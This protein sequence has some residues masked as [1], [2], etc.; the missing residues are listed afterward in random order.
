MTLQQVIIFSQ[1]QQKRNAF[2]LKALV[3]LVFITVWID[4]FFSEVQSTS[5]YLSESLLFSS[6]WLLFLPL[7]N[8]QWKMA[9]RRPLKGFLYAALA[10]AIHL[11]SYPALVW[12]ISGCF[13]GHTF[14][15]RQTFEYGLTTYFI[16]TF[17][18]YGLSVPVIAL[19]RASSLALKSDDL[20]AGTS[21]HKTLPVPREE[22]A[23]RT[24]FPRSLLVPDTNN[25]KTLIQTT[26]ILYFTA[27]SPYINV[28]HPVKKYLLTETLR[29]L[30]TRLS[31]NQFVRIHK[32]CIVN[33]EKVVSCRSRLNGD[34][35]LE[36]SD[37]TPLRLSR[38][39][40]A[41]F[42][43]RFHRYTPD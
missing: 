25:T 10:T 37:G 1:S 11:L 34:Y 33:V 15:Y 32:S 4:Y 39:Y 26:D 24:C 22:P 30:E 27:N 41:G 31:T 28:Y 43:A 2:L 7:L 18:I 8:I 13:Y 19:I 12:L 17:L 36:L 42:R 3:L 5:F 29:S 16:K 40:T 9:A 20:P 14:A 35:D 38:N 21:G 23:E 6:Y